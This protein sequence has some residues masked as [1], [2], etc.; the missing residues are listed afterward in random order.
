[1]LRWKDLTLSAT[2]SAQLGGKTYSVT[3]A[4]L[5]YQGKLTNSL[6]GR[7]DGM[8]IDGVNAIEST[9]AEGNKIVTYQKNTTLCTDVQSYYNST[10]GSRYNFERYTYDTS[11]IKLKELRLEYKFPQSLLNRQKVKVLQ[12]ASIAFFATNL[13]C[14]SNFPF[15][16]PE[17]G[18]FSGSNIVRGV[19][20]GSFPMNRSYGFNLKV[21]F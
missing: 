6:E 4:N 3:A 17:V 20:A 2:F 16:D 14:V 12:G 1:M 11:F 5:S 18:S 7:Y 19:E 13:F 8:V 9:D 21:Q 15:Y 10:Y